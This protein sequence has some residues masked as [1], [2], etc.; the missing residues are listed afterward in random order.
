MFDY[1]NLD[2]LMR[3]S[4]QRDMAKSAYARDLKSLGA[5][6]IGSSPIIPTKKNLKSILKL[7]DKLLTL[8]YNIDVK[9]RW[10]QLLRYLS[11]NID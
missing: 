8:I 2:G 10:C 4:D 9:I 3:P 7:V 11:Q 1:F 6:H 5:I